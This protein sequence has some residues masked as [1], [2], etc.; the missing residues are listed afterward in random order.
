MVNFTA[1][2]KTGTGTGLEIDSIIHNPRM[3]N[4]TI[5]G[6]TTIANLTITGAVL[7]IRPDD[8]GLDNVDNTSDLNKPVSLL[9]KFEL[10]TK[11][12][13]NNPVF[14]GKCTGPEIVLD[15]I[16]I[17]GIAKIN[18]LL[19]KFIKVNNDNYSL[20]NN[21]TNITICGN[22]SNNVYLPSKPV[23][24]MTIRI[25]NLSENDILICS[26]EKMYNLMLAATGTNEIPLQQNFM[27][28]FIYNKIFSDEG[29]WYFNF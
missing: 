17:N 12:P 7:G 21:S 13:I 4:A 14:T 29:S 10:D 27:Y 19:F 11:L 5:S 9:T 20:E 8:I 26:A 3:N 25:R 6:L 2:S 24:G 23:D 22:E 28:I 15:D 18:T 16:E 1:A